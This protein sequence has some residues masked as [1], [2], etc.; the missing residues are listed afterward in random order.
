[1]IEIVRSDCFCPFAARPVL[2]LLNENN[3][4][5]FRLL[6][7]DSPICAIFRIFRMTNYVLSVML[8]MFELW[9]ER[10]L[11]WW[12]IGSLWA[13][14]YNLLL[15]PTTVMKKVMGF[16]R[17]QAERALPTRVMDGPAGGG[18]SSQTQ[19]LPKETTEFRPNATR[20]P[21]SKGNYKASDSPY[22]SVN[23]Q[24]DK[25]WPTLSRQQEASPHH[26][27]WSPLH[28]Q[29]EGLLARYKAKPNT[30]KD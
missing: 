24:L 26:F 19:C 30:P 27:S 7:H 22:H 18:D 21:S 1:L 23:R 20:R 25:A 8:R 16:N 17:E 29:Y 10:G 9:M 4:E 12:L 6:I 28:C 15:L 14:T 13:A 5:H 3:Y 11:G 2:V